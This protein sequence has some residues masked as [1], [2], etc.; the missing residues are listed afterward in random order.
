MVTLQAATDLV[1][2]RLGSYLFAHDAE[3]ADLHKKS[4]ASEERTKVNKM[5]RDY[6]ERCVS[7]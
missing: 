1:I 6:E 4:V 3:V 5:V 7:S 2:E